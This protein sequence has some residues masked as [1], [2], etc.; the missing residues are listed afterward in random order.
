MQQVRVHRLESGLR[1]WTKEIGKRGNVFH[2]AG[3]RATDVFAVI[4]ALLKVRP[5]GLSIDRKYLVLLADIGSIA[6][7]D[8]EIVLGNPVVGASAIFRAA[9]L[10]TRIE[11]IAKQLENEQHADFD[12]PFTT[13]NVGLVRGGTAKNV[14]AGECRITLEWRPIPDQQPGRVLELLDEAVLKEKQ[15]DPDF[16]CEINASRADAGFEVQSSSRLVQMLERLTNQNAGTVAFG[17]EAAQMMELGA[18]AV[19][20]GPGNIRVAHRTGEFVPIDEL[21]RCTAI[22]AQVISQ[23]CA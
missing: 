6:N 13:L 9:R 15:K 3:T 17:T 14:I 20:L 19:V 5:Q 1:A 12:P 22:L 4:L 8:S 23:L 2:A 10:M 11:A 16:I 7:C 18:E 21:E